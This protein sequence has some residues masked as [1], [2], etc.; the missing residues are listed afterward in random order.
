MPQGQWAPH[1]HIWCWNSPYYLGQSSF[2]HLTI[3]HKLYP[4]KWSIWLLSLVHSSF[5]F[6]SV[7]LDYLHFFLHVLIFLFNLPFLS[8]F[9][10][11]LLLSFSYIQHGDGEVGW[12]AEEWACPPTSK[13]Q[14]FHKVKCHVYYSIYVFISH[15]TCWKVYF[16]FYLVL[17]F[18]FNVSVFSG[19]VFIT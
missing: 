15:Y 10:K 19:V 3:I 13:F 9:L 4:F 12:L 7:L 8:M 1:I 2:Y 11:A 18:L 16:H 17:I 6:L 14:I 5:N